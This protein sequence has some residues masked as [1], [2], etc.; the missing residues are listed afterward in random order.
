[1]KR[2]VA[3]L[4][5]T[6]IGMELVENMALYISAIQTFMQ[7]ED[8]IEKRKLCEISNEAIDKTMKTM[9]FLGITV[10]D[11]LPEVE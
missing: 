3:E 8:E 2:K 5:I 6:P 10:D 9:G 4:L 11:L 7:I 1:M